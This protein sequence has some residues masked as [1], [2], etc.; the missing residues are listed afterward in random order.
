MSYSLEFVRSALKEWQQLAP[1]IR[2]QFKAKLRERLAYPQVAAARLHG[3]PNCYKIKLAAV[4]YRLVYRVENQR[5]VV[6]VVAVGKRD[7]GQVYLAAA[8]RSRR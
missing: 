2:N 1:N 7:K 3:L 5:L 6:V 4:G 8:T